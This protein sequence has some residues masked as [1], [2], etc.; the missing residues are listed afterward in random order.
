M[1]VDYVDRRSV[2]SALELAGR[3]PSIHNSQ[4]WRWRLGA[5]SVHLHADL[6]R[7]LPATNIDGRD[8]VPELAL[9]D[10]TADVIEN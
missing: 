4:P 2:R 7:W 1:I 8:L 6:G 9:P 3:A 5:R 10:D